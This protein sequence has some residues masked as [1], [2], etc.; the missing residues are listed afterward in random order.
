MNNELVNNDQLNYDALLTKHPW[1]IQ[2]NQ[3]T[4]LSPD[5]D[6]ILCGL[7]MSHYFNWKVAGFYDGKNLAITQ[8]TKIDDCIF[9]DMDIYRKNI[10]SCGHHMV[11]YNKRNIP[12]TWDNYS[13]CI[14]PNILRGFDAYNNFQEKYPFATIHFLLCVM[15]SYNDIKIVLPKTAVS[16]LLYVDGTFKNLLNYPENC[17]SWLKFF[18]AKDSSSPMYPIYILFANRKIADMIHDL[19]TIFGKFKEIVDGKKRGGD[20]IKIA[21]IIDKSFSNESIV[22]IDKLINLL[23]DFTGWKYDKQNWNWTELNVLNFNKE[24]EENL[25]NGNYMGVLNKN[26]LSMAITAGKRMEYTLENPDK[27]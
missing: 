21:D 6:G 5:V 9:L 1:L 24:I 2:K 7:F 25:N 17:I 4:I 22:K 15:S 13:N 14:N 19:E 26:P 12:T 16:P 3:K 23:A 20:K 11:L 27:F 18:N 8:N 10:K